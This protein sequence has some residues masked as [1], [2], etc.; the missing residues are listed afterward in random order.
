[1]QFHKINREYG[2]RAYQ[3]MGTSHVYTVTPGRKG[4]QLS[5]ATKREL[6]KA[7]NAETIA[8]AHFPA[9]EALHVPGEAVGTEYETTKREVVALAVAYE[10][11]E[12]WDGSAYGRMREARDDA[13]SAEMARP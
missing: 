4:W 6:V 13:R 12:G 3:A 9:R 10:A 2:G 1:M 5:V 8:G 7:T 11:Y